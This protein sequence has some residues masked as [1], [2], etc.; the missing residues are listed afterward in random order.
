MKIHALTA[1]SFIGFLMLGVLFLPFG[2]L[3]A[4]SG[5]SNSFQLQ[6]GD[7]LEITVYREADLTGVYEIDPAGTLNFPLVGEIQVGGL[8]VDELLSRLNWNLRKYLVNPQV[9]ISR[10]EVTIKSISVL[11]QV[12]KPGAFDYTPGLTIMRLIAQAGGFERVANKRNVRI[13]RIV[14]GKKESVIVNGTA[15]IN[16][17]AEDP[18]AE[19][20][21]MIFVSE[22]IF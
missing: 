7:R 6:A 10:A 4:N 12:K 19:P 9:S 1:S 13:L 2:S 3:L 14:N 20:G 8:R 17:E 22:A 11:G 5:P 15:I 16:G 18:A 21:D